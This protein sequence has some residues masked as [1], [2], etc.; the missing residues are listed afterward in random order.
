MLKQEIAIQ[1]NALEDAITLA[2]ERETL[3]FQSTASNSSLESENALLQERVSELQDEVEVLMTKVHHSDMLEC[4]NNE[5]LDLAEKV[6]VLQSELLTQVDE[7]D[8]LQE[9]MLSLQQQ[10]ECLM[11]VL[12]HY[13]N[14]SL[15]H[16]RK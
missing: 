2:S 6:Q 10:L 8:K 4:N 1:R 14:C 7:K 3:M 16:Q 9:A 5:H 11:R 12:Y 15:V 13:A